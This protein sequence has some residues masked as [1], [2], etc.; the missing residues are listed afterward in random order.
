MTWRAR[1]AAQPERLA[2]G[3]LG[4][5]R[6]EAG[7]VVTAQRM[8]GLLAQWAIALELLAIMVGRNGVC[9]PFATAPNWPLVKRSEIYPPI[10]IHIRPYY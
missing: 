6:A 4:A 1:I 9:V 3:V 10:S 2:G 7:E 5:E 8:L